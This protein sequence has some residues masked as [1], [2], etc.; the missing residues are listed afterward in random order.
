MK[1]LQKSFQIIRPVKNLWL[2]TISLIPSGTNHPGYGLEIG[3]AQRGLDQVSEM[4]LMKPLV[5]RAAGIRQGDKLL[6]LE[7]K[8]HDITSHHIRRKNG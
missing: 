6:K 8:E 3:L 1:S 5:S 2:R 7:W 4:T